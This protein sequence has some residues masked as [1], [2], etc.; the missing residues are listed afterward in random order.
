MHTIRVDTDH[1]STY[2]DIQLDEDT[3]EEYII[4]PEFNEDGVDIH[5]KTKA[6]YD[7]IYLLFNELFRGSFHGT[8]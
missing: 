1:G 3:L 7:S 2:Y 6:W 4:I 8:R 5:G